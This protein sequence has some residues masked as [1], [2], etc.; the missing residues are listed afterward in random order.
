MTY[1]DLLAVLQPAGLPWAYHHWDA[2]P[3]PPY[4]VYLD[5]E[6][7][8]FGADDSAYYEITHFRLELYALQRD[9]TVEQKVEAALDAAHIFW[10]RETQHIESEGL[11]QTTYEIEV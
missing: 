2:P 1:D 8:N 3:L 4:G 6:T 5:D 7:E 10:D 9:R 11:Y